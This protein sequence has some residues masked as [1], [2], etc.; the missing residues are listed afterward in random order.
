[1]R[2][3]LGRN[4]IILAGAS[5]GSYLFGLLRDRL[6]AQSFGASREVDIFNSA[7][8]LPDLIMNLF[9]AALT[10][11][12]I[13]IF[14]QILK[15]KQ[16]P[17]AYQAANSVFT[18]VLVALLCVD[19]LALAGMPL[20]T[21]WIAPGFST[22]DLATLTSTSRWMLLSP[23][24][25][26]V[27]TLFGA[28][29]QGRHRFL[30]Y[31]LSPMLYNVGI[32]LGILV[33]APRFGI[34]GVVF[35]VIIGACLHLA[36]RILA[37]WRIG[38]QPTIR[39]GA[40]H[41][42]AVRQ[43]LALMGPRVIG[44]LAVQASLWTYNAVGSTLEHGSV[45]VFNFARNFQ[46][47]PVSFIGIAIATVLFPLLAA[48]VAAERHDQML[49]NAKTA[50]RTIVLFT[51]PAMVGM[52]FVSRPLITVFLGGGEFDAEAIT[53]TTITLMVFALAIP[54][55]SFQHILA[56]IYYAK[57][58]TRTPALISIIG[59]VLNVVVCLVG[60]WW[61]GVTGLALGFVS[62]SLVI[63]LLL[64]W[65]LP[66]LMD[67]A[68]GKTILQCGLASIVMGVVVWLVGQLTVGTLVQ[69]VLMAGSGM[70]SYTIIILSLRN[71]E[72]RLVLNQLKHR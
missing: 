33:F 1:M 58:D 63:D 18:V 20:I 45:A 32:V 6:L 37:S 48:D 34:Q 24:L 53:R 15:H 26:G 28:V 44:L 57:H 54:L 69:L 23:L 11:A 50:L 3:H 62:M 30:A 4:A 42:P 72:V 21:P 66:K 56:R 49:G 60:S 35:G 61:F 39:V 19:L 27:S 14:A 13:P 64:L 25:F 12:F 65:R 70:I 8:L 29:L 47:L 36:I 71:N 2:S 59:A 43:T 9:A 41:D 38:Y 67:P 22:A 55:E 17:A 51:L 68:M 40:F 46:S 7:F 52:I 5:A 16:E 10:T 31:A